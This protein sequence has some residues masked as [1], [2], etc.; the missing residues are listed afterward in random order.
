[1]NVSYLAKFKDEYWVIFSAQNLGIFR[2]H[3]LDTTWV[4]IEKIQPFSH[5]IHLTVGIAPKNATTCTHLWANLGFQVVTLS[6]TMNMKFS[7]QVFVVDSYC[8]LRCSTLCFSYASCRQGC[9]RWFTWFCYMMNFTLAADEEQMILSVWNLKNCFAFWNGKICCRVALCQ[10]TGTIKC[11][12]L[13]NTAKQLT[14]KQHI[15]KGLCSR[16]GV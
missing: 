4:K 10:M 14:V 5:Y 13:W 16:H 2:L 6:V 9:V 15:I 12:L 8:T 7:Q 11:A 1:M 3:M